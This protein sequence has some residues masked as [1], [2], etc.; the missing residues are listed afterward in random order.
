MTSEAFI[1]SGHWKRCAPGR[2]RCATS[3]EPVQRA[4]ELFEPAA[5]G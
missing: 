2:L 4:V 5:C 1:A 3:A